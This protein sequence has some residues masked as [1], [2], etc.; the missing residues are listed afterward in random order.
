MQALSQ[1]T[2]A[3]HCRGEL[4]QLVD[5]GTALSLRRESLPNALKPF[6]FDRTKQHTVISRAIAFLSQRQRHITM[7]LAQAQPQA[8]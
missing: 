5:I 2:I 4:N 3:V 7:D 8:A 1:L 6:M